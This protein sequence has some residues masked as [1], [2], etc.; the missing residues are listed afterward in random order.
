VATDED[1][2]TPVGKL[3]R[4]TSLDEL[5]QLWNV[6]RGD[7]ALV[8]PRPELAAF[9]PLFSTAI[10]RYK[11]RHRVR[12]GITGWA[13]VQGL[14]GKTSLKDRVEWDNFYIENWSFWFDIKILALTVVAL[15]R[16]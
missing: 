16:S 5:P 10:Y 8:R 4:G 7:M 2:H 1:P 12:P 9:T 13:Q 14:R 15:L 3:L 11:A 6:V